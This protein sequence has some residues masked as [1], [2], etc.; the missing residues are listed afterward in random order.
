MLEVRKKVGAKMGW[1]N[2]EKSG[3]QKG[4]MEAENKG[5]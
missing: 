5:L 4:G 2:R 1:G 3:G